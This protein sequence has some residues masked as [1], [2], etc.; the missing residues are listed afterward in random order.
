MAVVIILLIRYKYSRG[1]SSGGGH[2][3]AGGDTRG[4]TRDTSRQETSTTFVP[5]CRQNKPDIISPTSRGEQSKGCTK[6]KER[7]KD[8]RPVDMT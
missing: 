3:S 4:E 5:V 2:A 6:K 8:K 7:G 1:G